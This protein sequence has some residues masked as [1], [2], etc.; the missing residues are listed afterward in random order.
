MSTT[1]ARLGL[2]KPSVPEKVLLFTTYLLELCNSRGFQAGITYK[3]V[4]AAATRCQGTY[5]D[6][7]KGARDAPSSAR[8]EHASPANPQCPCS[9]CTDWH[10]HRRPG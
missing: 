10:V 1:A 4:A 8:G 9:L 3:N 5:T 2:P 6:W 7:T